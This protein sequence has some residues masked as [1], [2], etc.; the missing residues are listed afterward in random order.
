MKLNTKL[1]K[2]VW[3]LGISFLLFAYSCKDEDLDITP[4]GQVSDVSVEALNGGAKLTYQLPAD[5][6]VLYVRA[7]YT[8][9]QGEA[10]FKS[11]SRYINSIEIDGFN[12]TQA[13]R[14]KLYVVDKANNKSEAVEVSVTPLVSFIHIVKQNI[15]IEPYLGGVKVK[16][17]NPSEKTVF[18]YLFYNDGKQEKQRIL[19]SSLANEDKTVRGLDSVFYDFSIMVEDFNGNKTTKEFNSRVK[20]LYEQEISKNTWTLVSNLSVDGDK[21]EGYMVNFWDG[22]IDTKDNPNDNSYF[23]I[24]RDDNGGILNFPLDIVVDMN[25]KILLNRFVVWQR[26]YEYIEGNGG[27]STEYYY[28]KNEN[29]RS[30]KLYSSNN[31]VEWT[32]LGTFDIGDPRDT[33]GKVPASKIQEAI[34]GH[35]FELDQISEAFRYFKFSIT[36]GYGS[37]TN[38]YGSE[39]TLFGLDD[40]EK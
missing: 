31:K 21:Y 30:F 9:S 5:A 3:L 22:I 7:E 23:I 19:S 27:I 8:N 4:P 34:D 26:A 14:V 32:L 18:V 33:E 13:H 36:S 2:I 10:V 17:N 15:N 11:S 24:N 29:M 6:D 16:W 1:K 28:Y 25:K 37:E 20:P 39:I 12:D 35:E 40:V 38:V